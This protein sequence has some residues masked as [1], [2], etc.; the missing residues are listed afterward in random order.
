MKFLNVLLSASLAVAL[1][2]KF[3]FLFFF[4]HSKKE[5]I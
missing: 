5:N 1:P 3:L 4:Y 2:C